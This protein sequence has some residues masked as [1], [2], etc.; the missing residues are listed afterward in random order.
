MMMR[1]F[2]MILS[3]YLTACSSSTAGSRS[4]QQAPQEH[5]YNRQRL[6]TVLDPANPNCSLSNTR[7]QT[8]NRFHVV[9]T[10]LEGDAAAILGGVMDSIALL[11]I[12]EKSV[13]DSPARV[14]DLPDSA[15]RIWAFPVRIQVPGSD[16]WAKEEIIV[17]ARGDSIRVAPKLPESA[18]KRC[19]QVLDVP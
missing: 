19:K 8:W 5:P 15:M 7:S 14:C 6:C 10:E 13:F 4:T 11:W 3:T 17:S 9:S 12:H 16:A 18:S 2:A 1:F